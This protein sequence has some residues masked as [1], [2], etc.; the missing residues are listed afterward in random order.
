VTLPQLGTIIGGSGSS[1]YVYGT[2]DLN[3][4]TLTLGSN[5]FS[6]L[7]TYGTVENGTLVDGADDAVVGEGVISSLIALSGLIA[8]DYG[9]LTLSQTVQAPANV[10]TGVL[11][12][13][14][15]A[16]LELGDGSGPGIHFNGAGA[17]LQLDAPA[18]NTGT[19]T[20]LAAGDTLVLQGVTATD[21]HSA[22]NLLTIDLAGGTSLEYS[23]AAPLTGLVETTGTTAAGSEVSFLIPCFLRGTLIATTTGDIAVE[24]LRVGDHVITA[25]GTARPIRWLGHRAVDCTNIPDP[26]A[27][28][29][30]LV[31]QGAFGEAMPVR[32][33]W[34]SP[35]HCI[36][37][38]DALIPARVLQNGRT[39]VQVARA[40]VE[41]WHV[42]LDSHDVILAEGLPV[43]TF[44]D[45]G[46]R[47][48]FEGGADYAARYPDRA[49]KHWTETCRPLLLEGAAVAAAK[50]HLL[51]RAA[52]LGHAITGDADLHM[53]A[54]GQRLAPLW[55]SESRAAFVLGAGCREIALQ[56]RCFVPAHLDGATADW[57]SLGVC[58]ARLQ[59]DGSEIDLA[60]DAAFQAGW[61]RLE[62]D[63]AGYRQRW[64]S[65]GARLPAQ[66]RLV[67]LDIAGPGF[68]WID[69]PLAVVPAAT[70]PWAWVTTCR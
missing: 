11:Q 44:L 19:F 57:R 46:N 42:E 28:W 3:G 12:I 7:D 29:P 2:L 22:G 58:V 53:L 64:T 25:A 47:Y 1:L 14:A 60:D 36:A 6:E 31:R 68:Y 54:D 15:G 8:A 66:A 45:N 63:G 69:E 35:E 20:G 50:S 5:G 61:H 55:L 43:E 24:N 33:L 13:D 56:S 70:G 10:Y 65:G 9:L 32:D 23:L 67:V 37:T 40:A 4:G 62:D 48:A 34:L 38:Q 51:R 26:Q 27:A 39:I 17:T 41:Y 21:A 16:T 52:A 49:P 59:I 30:V 18:A